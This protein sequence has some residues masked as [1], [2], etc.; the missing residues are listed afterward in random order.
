MVKPRTIA[1][2]LLQLARLSN[3]AT[4]ALLVKAHDVLGN[5]LAARYEVGYA[6][7]L[8]AELSAQVDTAANWPQ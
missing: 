3:Q 2:Y 7:Q 5:D 1:R 8:A 6:C 4:R